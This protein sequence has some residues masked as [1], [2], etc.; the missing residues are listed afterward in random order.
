MVFGLQFPP[1]A[2]LR[3]PLTSAL[4]VRHVLPVFG[5]YTFVAFLARTPGTRALRFVL[6]PITL[7]LAYHAAVSFQPSGG[8]SGYTWMDLGYCVCYF[9]CHF[10]SSMILT[11]DHDSDYY[12]PYIHA[13]R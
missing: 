3:V 7:P 4:L 1:D 10:A 13:S 12:D 11:S 5:L 6:I 8:V 2:T 9:L